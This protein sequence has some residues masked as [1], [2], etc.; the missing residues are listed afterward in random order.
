MN[1]HHLAR[2]L[3]WIVVIKLAIL[4]VLWWAFFSGPRATIDPAMIVH[5]NQPSTQ[6]EVPHGQ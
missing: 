4:F 5:T 1:D 2:K 6:G 3:F